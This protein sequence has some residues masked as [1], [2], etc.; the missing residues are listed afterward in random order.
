MKRFFLFSFLLLICS[1]NDYGHING[2]VEEKQPFKIN[3]KIDDAT[4]RSLVF[5]YFICGNDDW[6]RDTI[7]V[8]NGNFTIEGFA[9]LGSE[10]WFSVNNEKVFFYLDPGE[11]QLYLKKDSLENYVLKGSQTQT[12][13]DLLKRQ[14][15]ASNSYYYKIREQLSSEQSEQNKNFLISQKDS[16]ENVLDNIDIDFITTRPDSYVSLDAII[17]LLARGKQNEEAIISLFDGLSE[18]IRT[19]CHGE[20]VL[21]F[22]LQRKTST[23]TN[24]SS[25]EALDSNGNLVKLS[26]FEGK[27][28][29]I[30]FWASWCVPC[31]EGFPHLKELYAKYKDKG[32]VVIS[33]SIDAKKDEQKWLNAIEKYNI[34][35]FVHILSCKN[36]GKNNMCDLHE[37][38][39]SPIPHYIV[40]DKSGNVIKQWR[41]FSDEIAKE[42]NELFGE[43]IK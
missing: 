12:D 38:I 20:R 34:G 32:L 19:C 35:E 6:I 27:Y 21:S 15:D 14:E 39:P 31:I 13:Y 5:Q 2:I 7:S 9:I 10:G 33:I 37:T 24:V 22:I 26:D 28:V 16:I 43:L 4:I 36:N 1:I 41:G 42:Q 30:D 25:L 3:G 29:L 18:N 11:M 8:T 17:S 40:I 23:M